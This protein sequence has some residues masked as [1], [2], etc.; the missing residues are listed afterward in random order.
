MGPIWLPAVPAG[1]TITAQSTA[2][3][4]AALQ[5]A[6][7]STKEPIVEQLG[8]DTPSVIQGAHP[9]QRYGSQPYFSGQQYTA[10]T[11]AAQPYTAVPQPYTVAT[12]PYIAPY[13][14]MPAMSAR[15]TEPMGYFG[16]GGH[17]SF[18]LTE[19]QLLRQQQ[20]LREKQKFDAWRASRAQAKTRSQP[21]IF[22]EAEVNVEVNVDS[23]ERSASVA[24]AR[25][26]DQVTKKAKAKRAGSASTSRRS[27][28]PKRDYP[29]G[30]CTVTR[31][32]QAS[33]RKAEHTVTPAQDLEAFKADMTSMLSDMLQASFQK[34]ASQFNT[35]SGG[36]GNNSNEDTVPKQRFSEP[37]VNVASDDDNDNSPQRGPE[38]QSEGEVTEGETDPTDT[39]LPTLEQLKMSKEEQQDYD[40]FS[41]ASVSVPKRPWRVMGDSRSSQ[42]Q[43]PDNANV[44]QAR[45]QAIAKAQSIK[46]TSSDRRSVQ[47]HSD[48]RQVQLRAPQDQANFPVLVP[49]GQVQGQRPVLGRPVVV[50]RDDIDSL[51]GEEFSVDL[52]NEAVLKEKQARSEILDKIA[53]FCNLNR[54]DPRV[55]KEV[56]GMRLPAYNA[57]TKKSIEISLPW[58]ST[59]IDIADLNNDIVRGKFNKSLKPLN[60]SK[61]WSPKEFFGASGYYV[62]NTQGYLAKPDSL[63]VPSRAPPAE[64]TAE[65]QPFFHVPRHPEEPRTR[66][67]ITS[68]SA[69]LTASQLMD[70]ETM[71]RKSAA[72]AS[73]A[74]S[75]AEFIDNYPRMPEGA[76]AAML[77]LKLDIIS[78][79]NYAWREVH[80]KMLLRRSIAL[81]CLERTLIPIDEDQKLAL[82]HA[83]FKGTTLYGGEL[84]KLQ[85]ANT[86]RAATFTVF[87]QPTAPPPSYSTRPYAGKSFKDK[88]GFK[89]PGGRG[90]GQGR[91]APTATIMRPGQSKDGQKALTVSVS[92]DSKKR[93]SES[94]DDA[95]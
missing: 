38:D 19:E 75:I 21:Q 17:L 2:A 18:M 59:M 27:P 64:R 46:S 61:P 87:P 25:P 79:L 39:G 71:S 60:P 32:S 29:R 47:H 74:L 62:H 86:K 12:Q 10:P 73:T 15:P 5:V 57:P 36:Q 20:L 84:A 78:F 8:Q 4:T 33:P 30:T 91:S 14:N 65:D 76:R 28:S 55:Q 92:T 51:L 50:R 13:N 16:Q 52:D 34:F 9:E 53:E 7:P 40:A 6:G 11:T 58:H 82:L 35:N 41:L 67:D 44:S 77:L 66:V 90:R 31:P 24:R 42:S 85:E 72:A 26:Q 80:N 3:S 37:T 56:M 43:P 83:P 81:D 49:Q 22:S 45:P 54:Q 95:P 69:S 70:Q 23:S 89:K 1:T 48:Q 68:G 63:V 93:K 88:K 94:Q